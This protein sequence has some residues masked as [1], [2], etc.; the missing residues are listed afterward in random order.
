MTV[1]PEQVSSPWYAPIHWAKASAKEATS[2]CSSTAWLYISLVLH[3]CDRQCSKYLVYINFLDSLKSLMLFSRHRWGNWE[4]ER[5][6]SMPMVTQLGTGGAGIWIQAVYSRQNLCSYLLHLN[7]TSP[8][9]SM[10][11]SK[12]SLWLILLLFFVL[13]WF[14]LCLRHVEVPRPV[15]QQWQHQVLSLLYY[16]GTPVVYSS[17]SQPLVQA[18]THSSYS[19]YI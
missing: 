6:S 1:G 11:I 12:A 16:K 5:L 14:W 3:T 13:V 7:P 2:K 15:P 19:K 4:T 18:S 9:Q 17:D 10:S 8:T